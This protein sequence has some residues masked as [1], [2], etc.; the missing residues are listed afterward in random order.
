MNTN[1]DPNILFQQAVSFHKA[2]QLNEA[3]AA[4]GQLIEL[5]P[6][7]PMAKTYLGM[8]E[9][10]RGNFAESVRFLQGALE[11]N[12]GQPE[13]LSFLGSAL[14]NLKRN[15]EALAVFD[16][17]LA[18]RPD[19]VEVLVNRSLLL[20]A[21]GR[22]EEALAS[23]DRAVDMLPD[24]AML[25]NHRGLVLRDLK[26]REE[27][28]AAFERA[29]Q[30]EPENHEALNNLGLALQ[31]LER[32]DEALQNIERAIRL[33]PGLATLHNN[34]GNALLHYHRLDEALVAYEQ[35]IRLD[36][37]YA[38]A[39]MNKGNALL[40]LGRQ[41]AAMACYDRALE[42]APNLAE[43][44]LNRGNALQRA[45]DQNGAL[46]SYDHA[47]VLKPDYVQARVHRGY[48]LR[49][50]KR[51]EDALA[52]FTRALE[53]EP[54]FPFLRGLC[55]YTRMQLCDWKGMQEEVKAIADKVARGEKIANPFHALSM[56]G[57]A[58]LR[59]QAAE[60]YTQARFPA[61]NALPAIPSRARH[62]KIRIGYF[63]ADFR[64]HPVSLLAVELFE[65][66]DRARFE[67]IAFSFDPEGGDAFTVRLIPAFDQFID[68]RDKTDREIVEL[69]RALEIDI[70]VDL[71][72]Y[73]E[74]SR[75][76]IFAMRPAPVAVNFLGYSGTM[77]ADY[78][79]YLIADPVVIPESARPFYTEKI[80][81]V[82]DCYL[83]NDSTRTIAKR[84]FSRRELLL[85]ENGF[86]FCSFNNSHK[87]NPEMFDIWMR[88]LQRVEGSVLWLSR[89]SEAAMRNLREE[90]VK[91]GVK[92][93]RIIFS[94]FMKS[95]EDHL[96][97]IRSA[98]L[99]LDTM[100][101]NAHTTAC[102]ALWAGLPLLTCAGEGM[103]ARAAA[104]LLTAIGVP[105]LITHDLE[106]YEARAYELA[107]HPAML[108]DAR[109]K[110]AQNRLTSRAFDTPSYVRHIEAAYTAMHE[111][112]LSGQP[113]EHIEVQP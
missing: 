27:S 63:S 11:I 28:L 82:P 15:E 84:S 16:V 58:A 106:S 56:F 55:L 25:H 43:A 61:N 110:L 62:Q 94:E 59:K 32:M 26:R 29:V 48:V 54:E 65:R 69:A 92:A 13:A 52:S 36:P 85:P 6:Q 77:G 93:D 23:L 51:L 45:G 75:T 64:S 47:I 68:V 74:N 5:V 72:G 111:R 98:D 9:F 113:P 66:H 31:S 88:L 22:G 24:L 109:E 87:L 8:L 86:V 107:T 96:A 49:D 18:M 42:L 1:P 112:Q 95:S 108:K 40:E 105:E 34:H 78:V 80:A 102:D 97:R 37:D 44:W 35:A 99:F 14:Q 4:Y 2:G 17:A 19:F 104:S 67:V 39:H 46:T 83:P 91:R 57:S 53:M 20:R 30:L 76:G 71:N 12:P 70:A 41:A 38:D 89:F 10:Q 60:I 7:H 79:D 103:A 100:P 81:N 73:T 50:Q 101:Y 3:A 21:M 33:K 90:A